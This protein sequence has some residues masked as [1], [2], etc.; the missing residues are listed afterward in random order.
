MPKNCKHC[1]VPE[2]WVDY[3]TQPTPAPMNY[4]AQSDPGLVVPGGGGAAPQVPMGLEEAAGTGTG[5]QP[6]PALA[7][8]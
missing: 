5:E 8:G 4:G 2:G 1:V 7:T 6:V 3:V